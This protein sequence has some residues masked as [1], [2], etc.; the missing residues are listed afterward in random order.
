MNHYEKQLLSHNPNYVNEAYHK[1]I[2][3]VKYDAEQNERVVK[4]VHAFTDMLDQIG[5]IYQKHQEH[6]FNWC[7]VELAR[8]TDRDSC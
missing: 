5:E 8:V 6:T 4:A 7:L 2:K 1:Q 3:T